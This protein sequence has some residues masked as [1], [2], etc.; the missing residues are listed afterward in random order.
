MIAFSMKVGALVTVD[1]AGGTI[2]KVPFS[3]IE[4]SGA[5]NQKQVLEV[6]LYIS[7]S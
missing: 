3:K 5:A 2:N 4:G 6:M 1:S 7:A